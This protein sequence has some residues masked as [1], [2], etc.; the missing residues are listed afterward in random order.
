M[1][2]LTD[3]ALLVEVALSAR[4]FGVDIKAHRQR[5]LIGGYPARV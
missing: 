1:T 3:A 4:I 2:R 5:R